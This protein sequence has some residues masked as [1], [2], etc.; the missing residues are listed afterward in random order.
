M[1]RQDE[2][3]ELKV[4][5][6]GAG[7]AGSKHIANLLS[8][9]VAVSA[10]RYRPELADQLRSQCSIPVYDSLTEAL[11]S[12]QDAVVVANRPDQHVTVAAEAAKRGLHLYIEKPLSLDLNGLDELRQLVESRSLVAESGY[13]L[14]CD[15]N[16]R[17]IKRMVSGSELGPV[18]FAQASVGQYLPDW[19]PESNYHTSY[20]ASAAQGGGVLLDLVHELDFL[21]WWFGKVRE[22]TATL[23]HISDL[24]IDTE[25]VAEVS[26]RFESGPLAQ[27]HL[28]YLKPRYTRRCE[29]VARDGAVIWDDAIKTLTVTKRTPQLADESRGHSVP[30]NELFLSHMRHFLD[31]V[32][33]KSQ[34]AVPLDQS[35]HVMRI[36][37]ASKRSAIQ[38]TTIAL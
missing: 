28:D 7:S 14:R 35:I 8:M 27:V 4:L 6:V 16:V 31:C 19:R 18:Y 33:G 15:P 32:Q 38:K 11:D 13:M 25:D 9:G 2:V 20:S 30:R 29:I 1:A 10:F 3:Q 17:A 21:V 24:E 22:V 36:V 34:P 12:P 37:E 23:A 5:V 26:L